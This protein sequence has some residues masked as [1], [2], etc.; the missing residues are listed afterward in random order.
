[1]QESFLSTS[2]ED[3][4]KSLS[5]ILAKLTFEQTLKDDLAQLKTQLEDGSLSPNDYFNNE[6]VNAAI[7]IIK[8]THQHF[9]PS[10]L[11]LW[12]QQPHTFSN[13]EKFSLMLSSIVLLAAAILS[14]EVFVL[15]FD[16]KPRLE[17]TGD[18][19]KD[20]CTS[21]LTGFVNSIVNICSTLGENVTAVFNM[22]KKVDSLP[23]IA[24]FVDDTS[25]GLIPG[26]TFQRV[27]SWFD[28][29]GWINFFTCQAQNTSILMTGHTFP[30]SL[31]EAQQRASNGFPVIVTNV[32]TVPD[33]FLGN[34]T[35]LAINAFMGMFC[36]LV[37]NGGYSVITDSQNK[38]YGH[39]DGFERFGDD[40]K[41]YAY[42]FAAVYV[43]CTVP[44]LITMAALQCKKAL[45][46]W[47]ASGAEREI[48][49]LGKKACALFAEFKPVQ[50][51][52]RSAAFINE[53]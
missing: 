23:N 1:M 41:F 19:I 12:W 5:A 36:L 20:Y 38:P 29:I 47:E 10:A 35:G 30:G 13:Y 49:S 16:G 27:P 2:I 24:G 50:V 8:Q 46:K 52:V 40:F 17:A 7:A 51:E 22:D 26:A 4:A 34:T 25:Q 45:S 15:F 9:L 3:A 44:A 48:A 33:P 14:Y 21:E 42:A 39:F 32:N 37:Q 28:P 53:L 31:A 18:G 11:R 43:L 6:K